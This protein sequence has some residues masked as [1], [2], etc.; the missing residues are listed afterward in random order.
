MSLNQKLIETFYQQGTT[1]ERAA[2]ILGLPVSVIREAY[3]NR[4][5]EN[6]HKGE[7][8]P[9]QQPKSEKGLAAQSF[10][11]ARKYLEERK[12]AN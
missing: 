10:E 9:K 8:R 1:A 7:P 4:F 11:Q 5:H 6:T 2:Q 3:K 12:N